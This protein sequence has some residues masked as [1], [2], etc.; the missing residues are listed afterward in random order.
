VDIG[1]QSWRDN[2]TCFEGPAGGM[3]SSD[4]KLIRPGG[5]NKQVFWFK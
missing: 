1:M 2:V 3:P 5:W 4:T